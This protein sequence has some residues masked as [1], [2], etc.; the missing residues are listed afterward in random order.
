MWSYYGVSGMFRS[1]SDKTINAIY[2]P[3]TTY[4]IPVHRFEMNLQTGGDAATV[5]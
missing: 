5:R 2:P 3:Q 4:R 1:T